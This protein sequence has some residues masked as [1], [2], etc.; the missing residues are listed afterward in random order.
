MKKTA[1]LLTLACLFW[2][3]L[4]FAL[5]HMDLQVDIDM[6]SR[7]INVKGTASKPVKLPN[8]E[9]TAKEFS[10]VWNLPKKTDLKKWQGENFATEQELYLPQ[11]WYPETDE[12]ITFD[13]RLSSPLV[14]I[15]PGKISEEKNASGHYNARFQMDKPTEGLALFAGPYRIEEQKTD[16][17]RLRTYFYEDMSALSAAYLERTAQYIERFSKQIGPFPFAGFNIIAAPVPVGYG[18]AGLTY[19]GKQVLHLPFIKESSLGHEILHNYWG[20]GV[21]PDYQKGNWAEGLTTYMA[22]Y[23]TAENASKQKA[24]EMRLSWLRDYSALPAERDKPVIEF[25]GKHG[26]ASQVIGY[27]KAAFIFHMLRYQLGEDIFINAMRQFWKNN[28]FKVASW[29]EIQKAFEDA[30]SR[31]LKQYFQQWLYQTG[32]PSFKGLSGESKKGTGKNWQVNLH[33]MQDKPLFKTPV[34]LQ[35]G[36]GNGYVEKSIPA[37]GRMIQT[38]LSLPERPVAVSLDPDFNLFRKLAANEAPPTLRDVMLASNVEL[39]LVHGTA[40]FAETARE[41]IF[42]LVDGTILQRKAPSFQ[43]PFIL[44]GDQERIKEAIQKWHLAQPGFTAPE[45]STVRIWSG[46]QEQGFPYLVIEAE[47]SEPLNAIMHPLPHYGK[48]G[49]L[50][51]KGAQVVFKSSGQPHS[52]S[53]PIH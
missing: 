47:G 12:L 15:L 28:Q 32:A 35:I 10:Y 39:V 53:A 2:P 52:I 16:N 36:M 38:S 25:V 33:L 34:P 20:N 4:S 27:H 1:L 14:T 7:Q 46:R 30:S 40:E 22:D 3:H 24:K 17:L 8:R 13:V 9:K 19:I 43:K 31:D 11:D 50:A 51:F 44:M 26:Q 18:F 49:E 6:S 41:L 5:V 29:V 37:Q 48:R 23:M 45:G 42:G 21:F